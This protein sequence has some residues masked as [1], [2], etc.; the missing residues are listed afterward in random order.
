MAATCGQNSSRPKTDLGPGK[1]RLSFLLA[2]CELYEPVLRNVLARLARFFLSHRWTINFMDHDGF[3]V[4]FVH[5]LYGS[6][7]LVDLVSKASTEELLQSRANF[8]LRGLVHL[9]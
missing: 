6:V 7:H 9:S 5:G 1:F 8:E 4:E 2:R 3:R